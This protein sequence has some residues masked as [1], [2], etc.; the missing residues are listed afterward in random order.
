MHLA[1][2]ALVNAVWDLLAK[3]AGQ[4]LWRYLWRR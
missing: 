3:S 4:P 1:A 2:A